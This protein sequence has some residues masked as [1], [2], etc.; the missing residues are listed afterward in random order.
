MPIVNV[1]VVN[2]QVVDVKVEKSVTV[3]KEPGSGECTHQKYLGEY[4]VVT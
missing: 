4:E 1:Q 2:D 3:I